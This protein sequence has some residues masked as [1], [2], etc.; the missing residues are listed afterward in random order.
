[1]RT[2]GINSTLLRIWLTKMSTPFDRDTEAVSFRRACACK[3]NAE[4]E[5]VSTNEVEGGSFDQRCAGWERG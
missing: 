1:M 2:G 4:S 5:W 3:Q